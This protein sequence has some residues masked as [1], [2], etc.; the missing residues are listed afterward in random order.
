PRAAA[1]RHDLD[2]PERKAHL[3]VLREHAAQARKL[4][5]TDATK[6]TLSD[7]DG[8]PARSTLTAEHPEQGGLTGPVRADECKH[9]ARSHVDR[10]VVEHGHSV[11]V[12]AHGIRMNPLR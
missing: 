10:D 3:V 4:G 9:L 12:D 8:S 5:T 7:G 1:H 6:L 11:E 2:H